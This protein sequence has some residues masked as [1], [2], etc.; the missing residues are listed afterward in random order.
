MVVEVEGE[1]E[2]EL[3]LFCPRVV[4]VSGSSQ[5]LLDWGEEKRGV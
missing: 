4:L 2:E 1:K 5:L 3:V